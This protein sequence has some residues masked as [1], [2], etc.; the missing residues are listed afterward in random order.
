MT[1]SKVAKKVDRI[2]SVMVDRTRGD[3]H[4]SIKEAIIEMRKDLRLRYPES[5]NLEDI[6]HLYTKVPRT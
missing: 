5:L 1:R 4:Q 2:A 3:I 6:R